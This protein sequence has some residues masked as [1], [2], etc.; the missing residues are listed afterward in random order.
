[1]AQC[2]SSSS[3]GALSCSSGGSA[4]SYL[5]WQH[6]LTCD[7]GVGSLSCGSSALSYIGQRSAAQA[8][9]LPGAEMRRQAQ[10]V[11]SASPARTQAEAAVGAAARRVA[12]L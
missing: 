3:S 1:M 9:R 8:R 4:L 6:S 10:S 2:S 11:E 5:Q 12:A 7:G